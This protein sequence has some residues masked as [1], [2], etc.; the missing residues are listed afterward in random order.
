MNKEALDSLKEILELDEAF[1]GGRFGVFLDSSDS[2][3]EKYY[4][5]ANKEGLKLF[6]YQLL[7]A[8]EDL[9][10][11]EKEDSNERIALLPK[12][13]A[14]IYKQSE[15]ILEYIEVP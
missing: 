13:N 7:C 15:V 11:Q 3:V 14:W 4:I 1:K 12:E 8:A 9:K 10:D 6:A 5:K 2:R